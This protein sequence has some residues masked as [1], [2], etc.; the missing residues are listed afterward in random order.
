MIPFF[1]KGH[2]PDFARLPPAITRKDSPEC[3][4]CVTEELNAQTVMMAYQYGAFPW[5]ENSD[6]IWWFEMQPRAVLLPENL[7]ISRSLAKTLR[8]RA[9]RITINHDF[10]AV[11]QACASVPREGQGGTW[12]SQDF[13]KVYTELHGWG[14]AHSFECWLPENGEMVLAGGLY[15]VQIGKVF[16]GESMFARRTDAS[17]MAFVWA[18]QFLRERGIELIDCQQDTSHLRS[19]GSQLMDGDEYKSKLRQLNPQFLTRNLF[20]KSEIYANLM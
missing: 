9:Y 12:I 7:K 18:V 16:Y 8:N 5:F 4:V 2:I 15:G 20:S 10:Q 11:I 3:L 19:L 17:K 1:Q 14:R 6:G 13:Q